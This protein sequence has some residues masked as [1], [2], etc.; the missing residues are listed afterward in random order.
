VTERRVSFRLNAAYEKSRNRLE[1]VPQSVR[2]AIEAQRSIR[3][4][5]RHF[6]KFGE[7][8]SRFEA[9]YYVLTLDSNRQMDIQPAIDLAGRDSFDRI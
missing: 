9:D 4:D 6:V 1:L 2:E 8:A 3:F 5:P 7:H